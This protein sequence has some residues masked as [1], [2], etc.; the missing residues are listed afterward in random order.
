V[1]LHERPV[2]CSLLN[3][4]SCNQLAACHCLLVFTALSFVFAGTWRPVQEWHLM[5]MLREGDCHRP[6][7]AVQLEQ[8]QQWQERFQLLHGHQQCNVHCASHPDAGDV[9]P[10]R[11]AVCWRCELADKLQPAALWWRRTSTWLHFA[12]E[13]KAPLRV[14]HVWYGAENAA[15]N[16]MHRVRPQLST[17]KL[18]VHAARIA[19]LLGRRLL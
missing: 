10:A 2:P 3:T 19:P 1:C 7:L 9:L 5:G 17:I 16:S 15:P 8:V 13:G 14:L 6:W 11:W 4:L 18:P 12:L